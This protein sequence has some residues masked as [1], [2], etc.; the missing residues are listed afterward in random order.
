MV[1]VS[2]PSQGLPV[3]S[4]DATNTTQDSQC[5]FGMVTRGG[6]DPIR[7]YSWGLP[8]RRCYLWRYRKPLSVIEHI[9]WS[10]HVA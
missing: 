10:N 1:Q 5:S 3:L 4:S 6:T 8:D 9:F 2:C 7:V